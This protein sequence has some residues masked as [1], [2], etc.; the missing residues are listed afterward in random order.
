MLYPY[1]IFLHVNFGVGQWG[2]GRRVDHGGGSGG[3]HRAVMAR[4]SLSP[5][6]YIGRVGAL[7]VALGVGGMIAALPAVAAADTG[8]PAPTTATKGSTDAGQSRAARHSQGDHPASPGAATSR[9][10]AQGSDKPSGAA[11]AKSSGRRVQ[12]QTTTTP[13]PIL[14]NAGADNSSTPT[15][16]VVVEADSPQSNQPAESV[17]VVAPTTSAAPVAP[18]M[19]AAKPT[20]TVNS[21][22]VGP[23]DWLGG[24]RSARLLRGTAGLG[25]AGREPP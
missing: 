11:G 7:A 1:L 5:T 10:A 22:N 15:D 6:D 8:K 23:L 12:V 9:R 20:G 4:P 17:H 19:T 24:G 3:R 18:A 13:G 25:D 14:D 2:L 16:P 21:P